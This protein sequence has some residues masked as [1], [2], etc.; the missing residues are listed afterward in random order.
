MA[1]SLA[2]LVDHHVLVSLFPAFFVDRRVCLSRF[3]CFCF[4]FC[5]PFP[6]F[7]ACFFL[8]ISACFGGRYAPVSRIPACSVD[9]HVLVFRFFFSVLASLFPCFA[10][11]FG[12]L[13]SGAYF[14]GRMSP[15]PFFGRSVVFGGGNRLERRYLGRLSSRS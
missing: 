1:G 12:G 4:C 15:F 13:R 14:I 8:S 5:V 7:P 11:F 10:A 3:Q 2:D 9:R 6:R